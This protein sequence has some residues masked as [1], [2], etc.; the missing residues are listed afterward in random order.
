MGR[1]TWAMDGYRRAH[2]CRE[3]EWVVLFSMLYGTPGCIGKWMLEDQDKR[4]K[5]I[6]D[7]RNKRI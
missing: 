3:G 4:S 2:I 5:A 6:S 1:Y 7:K